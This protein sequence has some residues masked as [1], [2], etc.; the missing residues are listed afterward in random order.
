VPE[1]D[2]QQI[3][4]RAAAAE[5]AAWVAEQEDAAVAGAERKVERARTD[6][7][8][9]RDALAAAQQQAKEAHVAADEAKV[10]ADEAVPAGGNAYA[11]TAGVGASVSGKKG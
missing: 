1:L 3:R 10:A 4:K 11:E 7:G 5:H 6:L 8:A 9:A 2:E